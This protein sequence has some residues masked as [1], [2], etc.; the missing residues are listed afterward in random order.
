MVA[1]PGP[2]LAELAAWA[3]LDPVPL[4][5]YSRKLPV[6]NTW[7]LP[8]ADKWRKVEHEVSGVLPL[9]AAESRRLGYPAD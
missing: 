9:V 7:S 1:D 3:Q 6:V 5:R 4:D 2:V 8:S